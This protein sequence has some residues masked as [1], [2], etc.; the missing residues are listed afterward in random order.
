[1]SGCCREDFDGWDCTRPEHPDG[2]CALV[3]RA[4]WYERYRALTLVGSVLLGWML[5]SA[6]AHVLS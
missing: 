6:I 2:P 5:G 1:V 3:P 4:P